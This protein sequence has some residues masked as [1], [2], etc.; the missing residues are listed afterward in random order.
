M[1]KFYQREI[2]LPVHPNALDELLTLF[3]RLDLLS[4]ELILF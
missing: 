4:A 3:Y 1:Y 2:K